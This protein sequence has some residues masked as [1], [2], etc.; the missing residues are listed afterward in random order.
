MNFKLCKEWKKIILKLF[1]VVF[2]IGSRRTFIEHVVLTLAS[3]L[4]YSLQQFPYSIELKYAT[5]RRTWR[6]AC[7]HRRYGL[8]PQMFGIY[9]FCGFSYF[10]QSPA[11]SDAYLEHKNWIAVMG[12]ASYRNTFPPSI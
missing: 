10:S 2:R 9:G 11:S 6:H 3:Y 7:I 4:V 8:V 1:P 12:F 5:T